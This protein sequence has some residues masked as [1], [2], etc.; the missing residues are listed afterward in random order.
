MKKLF[1]ASALALGALCSCS[2]DD[3]APVAD[4]GV[5]EE[6]GLVPVQLTLN[7][8]AVVATVRGNG[9]VG[10][11]DEASNKWN[12]EDLYVFMMC[13]QKVD[14]NGNASPA[15]EESR[16]MYSENVESTP[17]PQINFYNE[18]LK[19]PVDVASG[20]LYS[21]TVGDYDPQFPKFYPMDAS[22]HDFFAYHIDN[23]ML[24]EDG[25]GKPDFTKNVD[26]IT[27]PFKMDGSQD[28]MAGKAIP[29]ADVTGDC[30]DKGLLYSAKSARGGVIPNIQMKH[31]LT[32][33]TFE[34][35]GGSNA[36]GLIVNKIEV[37][38]KTSGELIAAYSPTLLSEGAE[39]L[40]PEDLISFDEEKT[41][42]ELK[43]RPEAGGALEPITPQTLVVTEDGTSTVFPVGEALM[44]APGEEVYNVYITTTQRTGSLDHMHEQKGEITVVGGAVAGTSYKVRIKLYSASEIQIQTTLS[45]WVDGGETIP[46]DPS[47][48]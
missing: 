44:V 40:E 2:N 21:T 35:E 1:F 4:N 42:L 41:R 38:S 14:D 24:D 37:M 32:R 7:R 46:V 19:A 20:D 13:K 5:G 34:V 6:S 17:V 36:N 27:V 15:F 48:F 9:T 30:S 22:L 25:D 16:W 11:V 8:P 10:G 26:K 18:L 45:A 28:L 12:G 29:S 33:F 43:Q 31:L 39:V 47:D 3:V 23:A